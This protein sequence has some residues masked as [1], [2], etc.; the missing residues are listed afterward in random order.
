MNV[1]DWLQTYVPLTVGILTLITLASTI[2]YKIHKKFTVYI[3]EEITSV[4]KELKPN[5][6]SSLKDQVNRMESDHKEIYTKIDKIDQ[7]VKELKKDSYRLEE[8]IDKLFEALLKH[9]DKK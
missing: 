4:A 5:G 7:E 2:I 3:K 8:K 6:G 9:F 1:V